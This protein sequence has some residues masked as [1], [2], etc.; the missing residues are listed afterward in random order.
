MLGKV[1]SQLN[2]GIT[3]LEGLLLARIKHHFQ[4]Q[5]RR[6]GIGWPFLQAMERLDY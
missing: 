4:R 2:R 5:V 1:E 3:F 6:E